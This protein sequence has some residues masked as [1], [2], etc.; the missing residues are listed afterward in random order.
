MLGA[1][2]QVQPPT[3]FMNREWDAMIRKDH[4]ELP[5]HWSREVGVFSADLAQWVLINLGQVHMK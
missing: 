5:V 4:C 2:P 3:S 1:S